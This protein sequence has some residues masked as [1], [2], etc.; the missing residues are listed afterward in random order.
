VVGVHLET[1]ERFLI[2]DLRADGDSIRAPAGDLAP[3]G[4]VKVVLGDLDTLKGAGLYLAGTPLF[5]R[6]DSLAIARG[7]LLLDSVPAGLM[8][9]LLLNPTEGSPILLVEEDVLV[10]APGQ[11]TLV[12]A[13]EGVWR[14]SRR[15]YLDTSPTGADVAESVY[16]FPLLVR[17]EASNFAFPEARDSGQDLRFAKPDGSRLPH[18]VARWDAS[19]GL[20]EVWVLVDTVLGRVD[21]QYI[22]MFW[23]NRQAV[24]RSA[25][26]G[27]FDT[28]NGFASVW[29]LEAPPAANPSR[30]E[31]ATA[32][33]LHGTGI[34]LPASA[35][36]PGMIGIAQRFNG[37]NS[38]IVIPGSA[39]GPL[40]FPQRSRYTVSAWV[41]ADSLPARYQTLVGKGDNQFNLQISR[42]RM[43]HFVEAQQSGQ[44]DAV[45]VPAQAG[46]WR[47]LT[48]VRDGA[49]IALYVDGALVDNQPVI[50]AE[51]AN[52][53]E[54]NDVSI[55][56]N[57][58]VDGQAFAGLMDEVVLSDR[59][60][61][62]AW[63]KLTFENQKRDQRLVRPG[64]LPVP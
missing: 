8:P 43:W 30:F 55:G 58:E 45:E 5:V 24:P 7:F 4:A 23:G 32:H 9:G 16:G 37:T 59:A 26:K 39:G 64:P 17:L 13:E 10:V 60:R 38:R 49:G 52:R 29:H 15:L 61:S 11:V 42:E 53:I 40:N 47:L 50:K 25:G 34:N 1:G 44:F 51:T 3:A 27:V 14:H 2:R 62:G 28:A 18:Q 12:D 48:G 36:V 57:N 31:D 63:I 46:V 33:G 19:A 54:S 21:S 41:R 20:A 56:W 6:V 35:G 22:E